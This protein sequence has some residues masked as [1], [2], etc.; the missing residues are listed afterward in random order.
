MAGVFWGVRWLFSKKKGRC[1]G[2]LYSI[3]T[4]ED[5]RGEL[6]PL[7]REGLVRI[8]RQQPER[9]QQPRRRRI[10]PTVKG[11][12]SV[13]AEGSHMIHRYTVVLLQV[14]Q[15]EAALGAKA[16]DQGRVAQ[17]R[18]ERSRLRGR[19]EGLARAAGKRRSGQCCGLKK[20]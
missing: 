10:V 4:L 13:L 16:G 20:K 17:Q 19:G 14:V 9:A 6:A 2:G 11:E 7:C 5:L 12:L 18:Q 1:R 3:L 8:R 15:V